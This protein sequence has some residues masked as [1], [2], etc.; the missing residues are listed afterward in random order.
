MYLLPESKVRGKTW[1]QMW[2]TK[3][4]I[5]VWWFSYDQNVL[6][7]TGLTFTFCY[8]PSIHLRCGWS[9]LWPPR[10]GGSLFICLPVL[11]LYHFSSSQQSEGSFK[12]KLDPIPPLLTTASWLPCALRIKPTH[13]MGR[14]C[15]SLCNLALL[16]PQQQPHHTVTLL[17]LSWSLLSHEHANL[18]PTL[19][20]LR[21]PFLQARPPLGWLLA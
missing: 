9:T 17:Q 20:H 19:G 16:F 5:F 18:L 12:N 13:P 14:G 21:L 10:H 11:L 6:I 4:E 2:K 7:F 8:L 3:F 15:W 1:S